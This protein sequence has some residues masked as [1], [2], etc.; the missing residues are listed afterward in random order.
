MTPSISSP[1]P[2]FIHL[3]TSI[4]TL[5]PKYQIVGDIDWQWKAAAAAVLTP[6]ALRLAY[7]AFCK[8]KTS[9]AD[10]DIPW[11][12]PSASPLP[13]YASYDT[14][15]VSRFPGRQELPSNRAHLRNNTL[16]ES[17][18]TWL[19]DLKQRDQKVML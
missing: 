19:A 11:A 16:P 6:A 5:F 17:N 10:G 2:P 9:P 4:S 7:L 8:S 1:L 12:S 13:S 18:F 3:P 15:D 14:A